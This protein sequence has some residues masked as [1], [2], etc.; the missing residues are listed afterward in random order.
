MQKI[1]FFDGKAVTKTQLLNDAEKRTW[2]TKSKN[3]RRLRESLTFRFAK[4]YSS[5][6][7][8]I[9]GCQAIGYKSVPHVSIRSIIYKALE[10][11]KVTEPCVA[12]FRLNNQNFIFSNG[13]QP[14]IFNGRVIVDRGGNWQWYIDEKGNMIWYIEDADASRSFQGEHVLV[15]P[16]PFPRSMSIT[17]QE[18]ATKK[19]G[20]LS[21]IYHIVP[22]GVSYDTDKVGERR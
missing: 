10:K 9:G 14:V 4:D 15:D 8:F 21:D 17:A 3:K 5:W 6:N 11:D 22:D 20:K 7:D 1:Y 16:I 12:V 19:Y 18:T 13:D 2:Q